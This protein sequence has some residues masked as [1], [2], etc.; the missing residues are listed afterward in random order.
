MDARR[1]PRFSIYGP[2]KATVLSSPERPLDCVLLDISA[3]GLKL[4]APESIAI[5]EILSIEAEDH[6]A[7]ADVRYAQARG[8]KFTIGCERIHVLNKVSLPDDKVQVDQIRLLID[9]YRNRI[10]TGIATERPDTNQAEAARLDREIQQKCEKAESQAATA[11]LENP[12]AAPSAPPAAGSFATREQLLDAAAAWAVEHWE[13]IPASPRD[14]AGRSEIIDRLTVHLAE[15]LR[16]PT[17]PP[18][19][20]P[21]EK[22]TKKIPAAPEQKVNV[23]KWRIPI[24][25]AAA[26][27]LGWG[28]SAI[29]WSLNS[30]GTAG[31]LHSSI[32]A[33]ISAKDPPAPA[34]TST[35]RHAM[36]KVV[37][38]TWV[39]ATTDGKRLFNKKFA[40]DDIREIEFSDKA[41]L[42]I[43]NAKGVEISLDGKPIGPIGG[44]GQPRLVELSAAGFRLLPLN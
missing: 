39:I 23:R 28:L 26:A 9:D 29:F 32:S 33:L 34:P 42:R 37:E 7:L 14:A 3:T 10:R 6:L 31:H 16:P 35:V 44:R 12:V 41:L 30:G 5:D 36:I 2:V 25:L 24:G 20:R 15:K 40:K 11:V 43:G 27:I 1:E 4:I 8:D 22:A 17:P 13:K 21:P 18:P 38:A 19:A